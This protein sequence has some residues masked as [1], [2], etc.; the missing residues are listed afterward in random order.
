[1]T[2]D[3]MA[4]MLSGPVG[5]V[6]GSARRSWMPNSTNDFHDLSYHPSEGRTET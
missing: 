6:R 3:E 5:I 4:E 2:E 1:M